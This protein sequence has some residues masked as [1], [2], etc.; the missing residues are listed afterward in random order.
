MHPTIVETH[1]NTHRL[2]PLCLHH[3]G[4]DHHRIHSDQRVFRLVRLC[5]NHYNPTPLRTIVHAM[6]PW[7]KKQ[8]MSL[9]T[10]GVGT[11]LLSNLLLALAIIP[12]FLVVLFLVLLGEEHYL[13]GPAV[14]CTNCALPH[15]STNA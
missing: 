5:H 8:D 9:G 7:Q 10:V 3:H 4:I 1:L 12:G 13:D 2:G 14:D 15:K 6:V 11:E